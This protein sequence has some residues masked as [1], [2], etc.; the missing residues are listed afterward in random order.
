MVRGPGLRIRREHEPRTKTTNTQRHCCNGP[1]SQALAG[2]GGRLDNGRQ[3]AHS[4]PVRRLPS[5]F[6]VVL[7]LV[8]AAMAIP[9]CQRGTPAGA[10]PEPWRKTPFGRDVD[11]ICNAEARSGANENPYS[12]RDVQ[13]AMWLG[14]QI[15]SD[16]GRNLLATLSPLPPPRKV[17][18]LDA[19]AAKVG[20]ADCATARSWSGPAGH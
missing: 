9:S 3:V 17:Q 14:Q 2:P 18:E 5:T 4:P 7:A 13:V 6:A 1:A 12:N 16:E 15:E 20:L 10:D 8:L 19:A 11:R